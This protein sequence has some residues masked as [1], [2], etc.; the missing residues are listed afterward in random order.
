[1]M[2]RGVVTLCDRNYYPGLLAMHASIASSTPVPVVCYDAGLTVEQRADAATRRDLHVLDLPDDP[3]I[4]DLV[5]GTA[6]CTPLQ[7]PGKRIWPLWICPVLI[8]AAPLD[9]VFWLD[10]DLLVLRGL[11]AMFAMLADG[12]VFTRENKAP[13]VT[14]NKPALYDLMPIGRQ[15]DPAVPAVNGLPPGWVTPLDLPLIPGAGTIR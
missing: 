9:E 11:D 10:C 8:R 5:E 7:K 6:D 2:R 3:L 12:P 13:E 14:P 15:F 4:A 1:M